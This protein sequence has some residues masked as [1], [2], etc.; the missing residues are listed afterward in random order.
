MRLDAAVLNYCPSSTRSFV[1]EAAILGKIRLNGA[2]VLKG[3]KVRAGDKVQI[4]ELK[5]TS[6]NLV[7]PFG[8]APIPVYEDSS[9]LAFDKPAGI[10]VQPLSS[11]E[12]GTLMNAVAVNYPECISLGDRPL[13]AGAIHRIDAGTSG[14]VLVAR[15]AHAFDSLRTQF[16]DQS[17][18]KTYLALVEGEVTTAG[19]IENF[20]I[21]DPS[22]PNCRMLDFERWSKRHRP[23]GKM[24]KFHAVTEYTPIAATKLECETRTLLQVTIYT[25]VTHQIRAQLSLEGIHIINDRLYGG[26][27]VENQTGH[28]L[29]SFAAEFAH[30]DN[31]LRMQI[32]TRPPEWAK[33]AEEKLLEL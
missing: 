2:T 7:K 9:L 19:R 14:L 12:T 25:G 27:A 33:F 28:C 8:V 15:N 23:A 29:H 32:K 10:A 3:A 13:M 21:H 4:L 30:P 26:F 20:L 1:K 16:S 6:D 11:D 17:V 24:R 31:S 22:S 18:K 5:E